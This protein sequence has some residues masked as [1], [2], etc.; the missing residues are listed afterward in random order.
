MQDVFI[1]SV[2]FVWNYEIKHNFII[3]DSFSTIYK[4]YLIFVES[5]YG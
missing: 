1:P 5:V 3:F 2:N 4:K